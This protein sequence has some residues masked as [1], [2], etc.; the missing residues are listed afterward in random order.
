MYSQNNEEEVILKECQRLSLTTGK[1]L[2]VGAYCTEA[3]SNS[4]ALIE[5]GWQGVLV[6]PSPIPFMKLANA[7]AGNSNVVLV[8][9]AVSPDK[10]KLVKWFDSNGDA[11]S[12][13]S[14]LHVAKWE[15]A[16]VKFTVFY[17]YLLPMIDLFDQFGFNFDFI[18]I[19]VEGANMDM[20]QALPWPALT[21][22]RILCVEHDG[23]QLEMKALAARY[24]F[25]PLSLNA[26][27]I[28]FNKP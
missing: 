6:E 8:N 24:G 16:K 13:T 28:I 12:S 23:R 27:N 19:D 2:D 9:A 4:R 25:H 20:F 7:Y 18:N 15:A 21:G 10:A 3:F 14:P 26:E 5:Q 11:L 17:V 1:L 22:T